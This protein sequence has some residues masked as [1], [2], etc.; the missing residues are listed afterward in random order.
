MAQMRGKKRFRHSIF[1]S[2]TRPLITRHDAK[3]ERAP[4][5]HGLCE[6]CVK[7]TQKHFFG[8]GF[9]VSPGGRQRRGGKVADISKA[10]GARS[11]KHIFHANHI[12]T[13]PFKHSPTLR[14]SH[15]SEGSRA[16]G[17]FSE[18]LKLSS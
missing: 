13:F 17:L 14:G 8:A 7:K 2:P 1:S 12:L 4:D 18:A 15:T 16:G 6:R 10:Y 11:K 5:L 3:G 9:S